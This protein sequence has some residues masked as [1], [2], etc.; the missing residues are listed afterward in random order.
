LG[1]VKLKRPKPFVSNV[2]ETIS[3]K[4]RPGH[5]TSIILASDGLWDVCSNTLAA[6]T[7]HGT[8]TAAESAKKLLRTA[9]LNGTGDNT[10]CVVVKLDTPTP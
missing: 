6:R 8:F 2:A 1:D 7:V 9:R 10:L 5:D 4:L 3:M